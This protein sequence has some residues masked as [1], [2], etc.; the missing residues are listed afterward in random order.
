MRHVVILGCLFSGLAAPAFAGDVQE[1]VHSMSHE[2]MPFDVAKTW[3]VFRMTE[4]GGTQ[5]VVIRD[6]AFKD[7]VAPV[8][9]HLK[10]EAARFQAGD[11][12]DPSQLHGAGMPG[13][14][15]MRAAAGKIRVTYQELPDGAELV[16]E[17][18]DLA[19]LT[20]I[21]RWFGAQLSEH[22]ADAKA[23]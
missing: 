17:T 1:H 9:Q 22:G 19:G 23:E 5:K 6:P 18:S 2:V 21:H 3:H 14:A 10:E 12:A 7:Q 13:L 11:Y 20:A 16:F 8:R 4:T 15:Q